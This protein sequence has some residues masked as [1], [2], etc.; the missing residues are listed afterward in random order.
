MTIRLDHNC[1]EQLMMTKE[2]QQSSS[3]VRD[4]EDRV[5]D[6]PPAWIA[7]ELPPRYAEL[8]AQI[9]ALQEQ[10]ATVE[11]MG[12]LLWQSGTPLIHAV[13]QMFE[14]LGFPTEV[15]E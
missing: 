12:A 15:A 11:A 13:R 4:R 7:A 10:A 2:R 5:H 6:R 1:T 8:A 14:A 9:A 3:T